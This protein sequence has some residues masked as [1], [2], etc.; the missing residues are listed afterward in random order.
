MKVR[1]HFADERFATLV[2]SIQELAVAAI[3]FVKRPSL[4]ANSVSQRAVDQIERDLRLGLELDLV[5]NV[6]FFRRSES[7]AHSSGRYKRASSK[8]RKLSLA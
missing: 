4:D 3:E 7:F 6:V 2:E 1:W 5:G 8:Q